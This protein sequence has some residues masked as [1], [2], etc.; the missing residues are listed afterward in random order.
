MQSTNTYQVRVFKISVD[1]Y[2][3]SDSMHPTMADKEQLRLAALCAA[4]EPWL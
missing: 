1:L 2:T 3:P 4:R